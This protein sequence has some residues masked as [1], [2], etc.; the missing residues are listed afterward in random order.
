M[1]PIKELIPQI[2]TKLASI[3]LEK[4]FNEVESMWNSTTPHFNGSGPHR[5]DSDQDFCVYCLRPKA[6]EEIK[7]ESK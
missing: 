4:S 2:L 1:T 5:Y 6:W 7:G 3:N